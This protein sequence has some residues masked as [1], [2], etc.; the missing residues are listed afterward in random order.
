VTVILLG[1]NEKD[2]IEQQK[3]HSYQSESLKELIML[4]LLMPQRVSHIFIAIS[5]SSPP[6]GLHRHFS[7]INY[8]FKFKLIKKSQ[9]METFAFSL[10]YLFSH[11]TPL[12]SGCCSI[13][14]EFLFRIIIMLAIF[15]LDC[16]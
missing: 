14:L 7:T 11:S 3:Q 5:L 6:H 12:G 2:L 15:I 1:L 16:I 10:V 8:N 4:K 13:E 9:K